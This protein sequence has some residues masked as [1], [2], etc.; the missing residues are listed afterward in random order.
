VQLGKT[1]LLES[2]SQLQT[3]DHIECLQE[4][5]FLFNIQI[6][7]IA[8]GVRQDPGFVIDRTNALRRPSSPRR[9]SISPTT[10]RYSRSSSCVSVG[11]GTTSGRGSTSLAQSAI[12]AGLRR[13][14]FP[15]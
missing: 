7:R 3:L 5:D 4:F 10:A 11:G 12:I 13:P 6:G 2:Q 9:S 1:L 14:V 15:V 8:Y